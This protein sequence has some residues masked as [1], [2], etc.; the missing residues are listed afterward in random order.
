[1][2]KKC[3]DGSCGV[4]SLL[5]IQVGARFVKHENLTNPHTTHT[6]RKTLQLSPGK[7]LHVTIEHFYQ[8]EVGHKFIHIAS[9]VTPCQDL[10]DRS[11]R[12]GIVGV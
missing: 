3:P 9:L 5:N 10:S 4:H 7:G 8:I 12:N 1:M 11:L 6:A 2:L